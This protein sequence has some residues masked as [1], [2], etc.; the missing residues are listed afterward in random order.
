MSKKLDLINDIVNRAKQNGVAHLIVDEVEEKGRFVHI[1]S[2]P[3]LNFGTYSYLGLEYDQRLIDASIKATEKMG[4]QYPSSRVYASSKLYKDLEERIEKMFGVPPIITTSLSIGHQSIMPILMQKGDYLF[5]DQQ[6]HTS[7]QDAAKKIQQ[8]GVILKII[9]H[10]D[11]NGLREE[12][13]QLKSVKQKVW[14]GLDGIYSMYGDVAPMKA[15]VAF[16]DDFPNFH[17][18]ADDAHGVSS[19]GQHGSGWVLSQ[20]ALHPK[21]VLTTGMAKAFGTMGGIAIIPDE[22][23]REY[24]RNCAGSLI[25]SGPLPIPILGASVASADIHLSDEIGLR[26]EFLQEKIRYCTSQ[27]KAANIPNLSDERT[28]IFFIPLGFL[29]VGYALVR[30]LKENGFLVNLASFPAVPE[31]CTGIRFTITLHNKLEDIDGLVNALQQLLPQ[32][33]HDHNRTFDDIK[34]A[35]R[36]FPQLDDIA[37]ISSP[38]KEN[39]LQLSSYS[40]IKDVPQQEWNDYNINPMTSW[41]NMHMMEDIFSSHDNEQ[42]RWT[43]RYYVIKDSKGVVLLQTLFTVAL[44]KDDM[45]ADESTSLQIEESRKK[46]PDFLTTKTLLMGTLVSEGNHLFLDQ[47][48]HQWKE[49]VVMLLDEVAQLRDEMDINTILLRDIQL[50]NLELIT[51]VKDQ[52]FLSIPMPPIHHLDLQ[53]DV[54]HHVA[55]LK[56]E[57]RKF[58]RDRAIGKEQFFEVKVVSRKGN[59]KEW[60]DLY[61]NVQERAFELNTIPLPL[62]FFEHIQKQENWEVIELYI[63]N[64]NQLSS[65]MVCYKAKDVYV[66]LFVGLD[67]TYL[68]SHD[69]YTQILWQ[70]MKRAAELE[71]NKIHLGYTASQHKRKFG[72]TTQKVAVLI[73]QKDNYNQQLVQLFE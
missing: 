35:F 20:V 29:G 7:V 15:L 41:E 13:E 66:P 36:R 8:Q 42:N 32:A 56:R 23:L 16:L 40:S 30:L 1:D 37:F 28:P 19:Y 68:P 25:F 49:A 72:A 27:L 12:L 33:L 73:Q 10:N 6:V 50:S 47:H 67:Y 31:S 61:K 59:Y 57:R 64:M 51:F 5:L 62:A 53:K 14:Y 3:L 55:H 45:L 22:H 60:F 70:T 34:R 4:L 63:N 44:C 17:L 26:Q 58:I 65:I 69:I 52:G 39:S 11:V 24:V 2:Q 71:Y 46:I 38:K 21:M 18:Y 54:E 43:F 48:S 9:R